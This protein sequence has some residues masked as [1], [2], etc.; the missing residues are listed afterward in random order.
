MSKYHI[1][2]GNGTGTGRKYFHV[3]IGGKAIGDPCLT[4]DEAEGLIKLFEQREAD[5]L[6][7]REA[8]LEKPRKPAGPSF[9]M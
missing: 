6:A 1:V 2:E 4:R 8:E 7:E 5:A 3:Y 9:G